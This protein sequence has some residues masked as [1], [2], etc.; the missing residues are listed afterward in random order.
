MVQLNI[1]LVS[2]TNMQ[3]PGASPL[4]YYLIV[5]DHKKI[6]LII[7]RDGHC[8]SSKVDEFYAHIVENV[9]IVQ[10]RFIIIF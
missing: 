8:N 2:V 9:T 4:D 3:K 5:Y 7:Y 10:R 6:I 1:S